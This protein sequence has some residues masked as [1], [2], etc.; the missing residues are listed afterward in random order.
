M[1]VKELIKEL[2]A[3]DPN[4]NVFL[5]TDTEGN[6]FSTT[7]PKDSQ[8]ATAEYYK[9]DGTVCIWPWEEGKEYEDMAPKTYKKMMGDRK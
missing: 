3:C 8:W 7:A 4:A 9:E 6:S 1:K 5:A 2:K